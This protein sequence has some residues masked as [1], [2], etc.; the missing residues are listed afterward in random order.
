[1]SEPLLSVRGL[2]KHFKLNP[3]G[4]FEVELYVKFPE[5]IHP[6]QFDLVVGTEAS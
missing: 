3:K 5:D 2:V 1:M 6:R 4:L